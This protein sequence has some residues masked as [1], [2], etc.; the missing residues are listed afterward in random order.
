MR[1][2]IASRNS[3][4]LRERLARGVRLREP[5]AFAKL[6]GSLIEMAVVTGVLARI[7]RA[8]VVSNGQARGGGYLALTFTLGAVFLLLMVAAHLSRFTLRDWAWRAPAFAAVE[9]AAEMVVSAILISMSRE[10][11]GTSAASFQD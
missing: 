6:A 4:L 7:Y 11:L 1:D 3:E 10:P 9:G 8:M 5:A 2:F